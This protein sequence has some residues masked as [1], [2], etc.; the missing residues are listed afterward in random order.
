MSLDLR[1]CISGD[2]LLTRGGEVLTYVEQV[3]HRVKGDSKVTYSHVE[4]IMHRVRYYDGAMGL[5][6]NNGQ[7]RGSLVE[8]Q[9]DIVKILTFQEPVNVGT[10]ENKAPLLDRYNDLLKR[11]GCCSHDGAIKEIENLKKI[12]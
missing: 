10:M 7:V 2:K 12:S 11:L 9:S 1:Y 8:H 6:E 5:R 3:T 4:I